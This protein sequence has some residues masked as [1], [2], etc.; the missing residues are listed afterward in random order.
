MLNEFFPYYADILKALA[1]PHRLEIIHLL[2][3]REMC[4]NDM[5]EMIDLPQAN[6]SQHLSILR[7]AGVVTKRREGKQ[8]YYKLA[9]KNV[10]KACDLMKEVLVRQYK[11]ARDETYLPS[12]LL[13][14]D[15]T[16]FDPVCGMEITP[17]TAAFSIRY[18]DTT[19]YFCASGCLKKFHE[20]PDKYRK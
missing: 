6:I 14:I 10:I 16:V 1:Q 9:H 20:D 4:V 17:G 18:Q 8:M 12:S 15:S 13:R 7:E 5:C 3:D 19:N 11:Q 2:R